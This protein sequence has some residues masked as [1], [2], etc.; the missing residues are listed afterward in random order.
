MG[1]A[2]LS[3]WLSSGMDTSRFTIVDPVL[4]QA[5]AGVGLL[6][7][8]PAE[9]FD[10]ILLAIK[11]QILDEVVPNVVPVA[12]ETTVM[13]SIMAGIELDRLSAL[14]P[15][16]SGF[17][18][19]M[20]NLAASIG[21]SPVALAGNGIDNRQRED[22]TSLMQ[23][24]GTPEWVAEDQFDLI[25]ALA[26]SGPAFVYRFIDS[27]G[28]GAAALGLDPQQAG[29]LAMAMVEGAAQLAAASSESPGELANRVASPGGTTE[30][31]LKVLDS[32][33]AMAHLIEAVLRAARDRSV[34][35][36]RES[37]G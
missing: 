22:I 24:L 16:A 2:M 6:R 23:P 14:F 37:G 4:D 26:G 7:D 19:I 9:Q 5:P 11:P 36:A 13:M 35:M 18:R 25:T 3:G 21:K 15:A 32:D 8:V 28:S 31:G 12:T 30:A 27:L 34:E 10:A 33:D 20:P 29:R 17:V 1:G